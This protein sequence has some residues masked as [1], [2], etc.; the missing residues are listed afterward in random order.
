MPS[1]RLT[2]A[3]ALT[4]ARKFIRENPFFG[5]SLTPEKFV[6]GAIDTGVWEITDDAPRS[7]AP[8]AAGVQV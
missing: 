1:Y 4:A 8:A 2:R 7:N 5:K 3:E 6:L